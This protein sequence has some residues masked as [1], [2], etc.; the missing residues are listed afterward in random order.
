MNMPKPMTQ[1]NYDKLVLKIANI[2]E[3]VPQVTIGDVVADLRQQCQNDD[4]TLDIGAYCNGTWQ[5]RGF[6]SLNGVFAALS[7]DSGKVLDVEVMSRV[8]RGCS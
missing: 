8:S 6:F 1:K 7:I 5:R 3:E 4:E 2:T